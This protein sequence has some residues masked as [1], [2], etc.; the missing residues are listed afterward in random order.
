M[1]EWKDIDTMPINE[2]VLV[3]SPFSGPHLREQSPDGTLYDDN[4]N[5]DDSEIEWDLWAEIPQVKPAAPC[6]CAGETEQ[7]S[8]CQEM[9]HG[10]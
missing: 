1:S 5:Y 8:H 6:A 7:C 3:W 4:N 2:L 9:R 10:L